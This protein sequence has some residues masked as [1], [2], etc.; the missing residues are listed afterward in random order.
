MDWQIF[1]DTLFEYQVRLLEEGINEPIIFECWAEDKEH[2]VEQAVDAYPG[3]IP[4]L[5]SRKSR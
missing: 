2:A 3:C 5:T 4:L 1:E